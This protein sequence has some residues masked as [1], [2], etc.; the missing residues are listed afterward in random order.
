MPDHNAPTEIT[1]Q[2]SPTSEQNQN[3]T[4]SEY[5]PLLDYLQSPE[6]APIDK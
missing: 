3:A 5:P 2:V 6:G 1:R 4:E